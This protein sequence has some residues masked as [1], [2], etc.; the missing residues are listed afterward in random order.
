M[1]VLYF[2]IDGL[3]I[4]KKEKTNPV[5]RYALWKNLIGLNILTQNKLI[6]KKEYMMKALDAHCGVEGVP[7]SA[8]GQTALFTGQN[9]SKILGG[10][11]TG[12]PGEILSSLIKEHSILKTLK[13]KGFKVSSA[14]SYSKDYF[15]R[16]EAKNRKVSASTLTIKAADINFRFLEDLRA[17]NALFADINRK[18]IKQYYPEFSEIAINKA[19]SHLK[20]L[21]EQN[22]FLMFEYFLTD[23]FGHKANVKKT[24]DILKTIHTFLKRLVKMLDLK[25][26]S[27][28]ICSDH[29]NIE[30]CTKRSHTE[31]KVPFLLFSKRGD[32]KR[33]FKNQKLETLPDLPNAI[34][35]AFE[36]GIFRKM[37]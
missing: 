10:H 18:F 25:K 14:N 16:V 17:G 27:I 4:G 31:N 1:G 32:I 22:D 34:V 29:G 26:H 33:F 13:E 21:L 7:Q 35:K 37:S 36:A 28:I 30:D 19:A 3:G 23:L 12:F 9:A 2:F 24:K 5:Y 20:G 11:L 6:Y 15:K 8:T